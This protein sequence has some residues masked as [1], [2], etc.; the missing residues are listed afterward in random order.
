MIHTNGY[1]DRVDRELALEKRQF[2]HR[3]RLALSPVQVR[4]MDDQAHAARTMWN[5]LHDSWTMLPKECRNLVAADAAIRRARKDIDW[6]AVLPA[7]AAQA[8]L[9]T[10]FQAWK[11]CWEGRAEEPNFKARSDPGPDTARYRKN[12]AACTSC[13]AIT[14]GRGPTRSTMSPTSRGSGSAQAVAVVS[15]RPTPASD[16]WVT[17]RK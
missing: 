6:L 5:L 2:G 1:I 3:A 12:P 10:Y 14:T 11:N 17:V 4:L 16:R 7:Q 15:S 8:V 9:K 13:P